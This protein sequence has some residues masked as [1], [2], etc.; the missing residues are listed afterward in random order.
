MLLMM[1]SAL[2]MVFFMVCK[3]HATAMVPDAIRWFLLDTWYRA[4]VVFLLLLP[5]YFACSAPILDSGHVQYGW[6]RI[7]FVICPRSAKVVY[8]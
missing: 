3:K 8:E 5:I 2:S 1:R 7:R 6:I 4:E